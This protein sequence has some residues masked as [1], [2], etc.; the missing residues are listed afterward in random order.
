MIACMRMRKL[1]HGQSVL[2]CIPR[3]IEQ[4][5]LALKRNSCEHHEICIADVLCWAM[6]ETCRELRR[7]VPLWITQGLRFYRQ[8]TI[9]D[10]QEVED[11]KRKA[12][13]TRFL[14]DEAQSIEARY[15]P[16]SD[17]L[18]LDA[19]V[20]DELASLDT[21]LATF[22]R[23]CSDF[24]VQEMRSASLEEEQERELAPEN[25]QERQVER[26]P[27]VEPRQHVL[28]DSLIHLV[29][30]GEFLMSSEAFKPAFQALKESTGGNTLISELNK[31]FPNL[32]VTLD[33]ATT[34]QT[35][36]AED[37]Q[38]S[39]QHSVQWVMTIGHSRLLVISPYEAQHLL[40]SIAKSPHVALHLYAPRTI[41]EFAAQDLRLY[42]IT[43]QDSVAQVSRNAMVE[44]HLFA[45]QLYHSS[46]E[47]YTLVCD[48]LGLAW[49]TAPASMTIDADGF[50][51]PGLAALVNKSSFTKSPVAF[52]R[53]LLSKIR[54]DCEAIDKTHMGKI[55]AGVLLTEEDFDAKDSTKT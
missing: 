36:H 5:I 16:N 30:T 29:N 9:W 50:I 43:G 42:T 2:F 54:Q 19:L 14:E 37:R 27:K 51:P 53:A 11:S 52:F 24:G 40:D 49:K 10:S 44:L 45:G 47:E 31:S 3:E 6:T 33:F 8:Q 35:E 48:A 25:E 41:F 23:Q 15:S 20:T 28:H 7:I 46:F 39:F 18:G 1:G 38:D 26:P 55:L 4:K 13:A 12:W 21:T 17:C 22:R 34:V 32:Y